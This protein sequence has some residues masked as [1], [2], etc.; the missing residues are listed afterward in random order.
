MYAFM[1]VDFSELFHQ[2]SKNHDKGHQ[3]IPIHYVDWK[4]EWKTTY[5]KTYPRL[6]K[7]TLIDNPPSADLFDLVKKRESRRDF[8]RGDMS[9]EEVSILLKYSCGEMQGNGEIYRRRAQPSGGARFPIEVYLVI[10]RSEGELKAGVYHY[11]VKNHMLDV[12]WEKEFNDND[13]GELFSYSWVKEATMGIVMT[14]V[15][16]RAQDKYGERGYRHIL[17]EAGHI[18]QN[19]YL[20]STA[21]NLKCCAIGGTI[22]QNIEKILDIDGVTESLVYACAIGK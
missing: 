18:C 4:E 21:L 12:L 22:D 10:F 9:L 16:A 8:K 19:I 11:G 17:L 2:A 5:Y 7:V 13:I 15:F 3:P 6:P 14:A 1:M 20:V